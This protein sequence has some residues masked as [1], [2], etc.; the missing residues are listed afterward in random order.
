MESFTWVDQGLTCAV[1]QEA[2]E[3]GVQ[4]GWNQDGAEERLGFQE[5]LTSPP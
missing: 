2:E 3:E 1:S 4:A 5:T